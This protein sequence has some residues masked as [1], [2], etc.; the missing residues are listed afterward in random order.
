M[1]SLFG[2]NKAEKKQVQASDPTASITKINEQINNI[3]KKEQVLNVKIKGLLQ[4]ALN[5]KKTNNTKAALFDLRK[6]KLYEQ[7]LVKI[8]GMK[9][10]LE[11]QKLA[12]EQ[13]SQ[14]ADVFGTL[15]EADQA[16]K[17]ASKGVSVEAFEDLKDAMDEQQNLRNEISEFFGNQAGL[18]D[19]DLQQEL[20]DLENQN[21]E[22]ELKKF[23]QIA[24]PQNKASISA[25]KSNYSD[26]S[27]ELDELK[28]L[29]EML[30]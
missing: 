3:D 28:R 7:E 8:D 21:A 2:S 14:D 12:L 23:D 4:D 27:K 16:V 29:E 5:H 25:P 10:M 30:Q 22:E 19:P 1:F 17:Q 15:K 18:D 6:K 26:N 20:A 13:A 24:V 9:F 11:Q